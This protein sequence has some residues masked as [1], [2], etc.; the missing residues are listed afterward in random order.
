MDVV[1]FETYKC[2]EKMSLVQNIFTRK[3]V[4]YGKIR[5][6]KLKNP[7]K[8]KKTQKSPIKLKKTHL[9]W[10]KKKNPGFFQPWLQLKFS[11]S[12]NKSKLGTGS[13]PPKWKYFLKLHRFLS[14]TAAS[15]SQLQ[16]VSCGAVIN[17]SLVSRYHGYYSNF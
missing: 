5:R 11:C 7:K 3:I 12:N 10:V 4:F 14:T 17:S 6:K 16:H 8:L 2:H 9:G 13:E 15:N 1:N